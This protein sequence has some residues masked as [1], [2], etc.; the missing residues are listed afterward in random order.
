METI[1]R[2]T[3]HA[4]AAP[5]FYHHPELLVDFR[6][7]LPLED[8]PK[9]RWERVQGA[10]KKFKVRPKRAKMATSKSD[11]RQNKVMG[12]RKGTH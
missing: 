8:T 5:L 12:G 9:S 1:T 3:A 11:N 7:F 6:A 4:Q 2:E 10:L